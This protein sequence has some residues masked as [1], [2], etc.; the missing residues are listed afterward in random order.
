MLFDIALFDEDVLQPSCHVLEASRCHGTSVGFAISYLGADE[1]AVE[2]VG[3][4]GILFKAGFGNKRKM[5]YLC[6]S[7][8][9]FD[10]LIPFD[11]VICADELLS[12]GPAFI[13]TQRKEYVLHSLDG[14]HGLS[15][16][17]RYNECTAPVNACHGAGYSLVEAT[18]EDMPNLLRLWK[19]WC[20]AKLQDPRTHA[21]SF[22]GARYRR[23]VEHSI[24]GK[25]Q[26]KCFIIKNVEG[27]VISCRVLNVNIT[28]AFDLA[29][30]SDFTI[31]FAARAMQYLSLKMLF[32]SG[33]K[34]VNFGESTSSRLTY[35]KTRF[36]PAILK[37]Y[38]YDRKI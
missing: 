9:A 30:F 6:L 35:F 26:S 2:Q 14:V 32:E 15:S 12:I 10:P 20:D 22:T 36:A 11:R 27:R 21:I 4:S 24:Q 19:E 17:H 38:Q 13:R 1:R 23:C 16:K 7:A 34:E 3:S 18:N 29:F 8:E 31:P 5:T 25:Y 37:I 33:I 28:R